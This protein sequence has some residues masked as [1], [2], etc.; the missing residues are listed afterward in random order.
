MFCPNC[1]KKNDDE[2]RFCEFCGH[3]LKK[4]QQHLTERTDSSSNVPRDK[5]SSFVGDKTLRL[6]SQGLLAFAILV[7]I[8]FA[9]SISTYNFKVRDLTD[10]NYWGPGQHWVCVTAESVLIPSA[11]LS[12]SGTDV[13]NGREVSATIEKLKPKAAEKYTKKAKDAITTG[14]IATAIAF[15]FF[16]YVKRLYHKYH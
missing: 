11:I 10:S 12:A 3:V 9:L 15:A 13:V 7:T 16:I 8:L 14:C 1:G 5:I 4:A 2:N 6:F